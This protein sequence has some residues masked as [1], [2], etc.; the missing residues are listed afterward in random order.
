[1]F[2]AF[3]WWGVGAE[4]RVK[5]G[6]G[7]GVGMYMIGSVV[8]RCSFDVFVWLTAPTFASAMDKERLNS[9]AMSAMSVLALSWA[10]SL[11]VEASMD[12]SMPSA[13][14]GIVA[15]MVDLA[16]R[17]ASGTCKGAWESSEKVIW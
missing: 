12:T 3:V 8:T 5:A 16:L 7:D 17:R 4:T 1:M 10:A 13:M 14:V 6:R 9:C 2:F 11:I 15:A